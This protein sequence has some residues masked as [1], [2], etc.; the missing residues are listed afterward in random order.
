MRTYSTIQIVFCT[1]VLFL[2]QPMTAFA[3]FCEPLP[4]PAGNIIH[5]D[6]SQTGKLTSIVAGA[7][8]GDTILLADANYLLDGVYLWV[9]TPGLTIRSAS[10]NREAVVLDGNYKTT[11]IVTVTASHVTIA[12]LTLRRAKFHGVHVVPASVGSED[13]SHTRIHNVHIID[14]GQQAVKINPYLE[15]I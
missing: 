1:I 15:S 5:V 10:G 2:G 9:S 7:S 3:R 14:P 4:P 13:I 6:P 12:D 11:K 8:Q